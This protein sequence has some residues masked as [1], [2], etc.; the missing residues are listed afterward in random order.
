MTR[1]WTV[2]TYDNMLFFGYVNS[3]FQ[4]SHQ[5]LITAGRVRRRILWCIRARADFTFYEHQNC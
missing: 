4:D 2:S 5:I 1:C 3:S